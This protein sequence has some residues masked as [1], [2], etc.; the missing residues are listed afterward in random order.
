MSR[1]SLSGSPGPRSVTKQTISSSEGRA[2]TVPAPL[3]E[4]SGYANLVHAN[5]TRAYGF[6]DSL[7]GCLHMATN[8]LILM[9]AATALTH[10]LTLVTHNTQDFLHVPGLTIIDWLNP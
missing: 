10:G 4:I 3:D 5:Q 6:S 7:H 9:I 8:T 1:L 2:P